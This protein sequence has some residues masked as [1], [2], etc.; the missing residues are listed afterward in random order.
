MLESL[1]LKK[2]RVEVLKAIV[3]EQNATKKGEI[4]RL[5]VG[6]PVSISLC[7]CETVTEFLCSFLIFCF[8]SD[9]FGVQ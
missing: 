3:G 9:F 4:G 2:E 5:V 1:R 6:V 7:L 8:D